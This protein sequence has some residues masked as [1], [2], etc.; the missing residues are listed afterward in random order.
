VSL[1]AYLALEHLEVLPAPLARPGLRIERALAA[2]AGE[3]RVVVR[4]PYFSLAARVLAESDLVLT[5]TSAF[6]RVLAEMTPL[7]IVASP[8]KLP[9]QRFSMIWLRR[10]DANPVHARFR[11]LVSQVCA[12]RFGEA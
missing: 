4:V 5:M 10:H 3:R 12:E 11:D 9:P 2:R 1:K 7:R 6:A 8:V